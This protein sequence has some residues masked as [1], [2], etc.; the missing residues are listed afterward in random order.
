MS[1]FGERFRSAGYSVPKPLI[2]ID[3]KT[4][5]EHVID[6]FP[7]E[8]NFIFVCNRDHLQ[9]PDYRMQ[10][11]LQ[12]AC[13]TGKIVAIAPHRKG[14][15]H[16][17]MQAIDYLDLEK[18][19]VINYCDFTCFWDWPDFKHFVN[20]TKCAGAI[21]AYRGFHPHSLGSTYYAYLEESAG[22]WA[23]NI[24]EKKPFTS[25]PKNEFA[26]TGTYYFENGKLMLW[27][28]NEMIDRELSVNDEF[29]VSMAYKPLFDAGKKIAIY[30][31]QHFMQWGTPQ[32]LI[33]Y[34]QWSDLFRRLVE[35]PLARSDA[36]HEGYL[37]IPMAGLGSRFAKEG[38]QD[39]KPLIKV[40]GYP[41]VLRSALDMPKAKQTIFVTRQDLPG[42][43][44]IALNISQDIESGRVV[45]LAGITEGQAETCLLG[46]AGCDLDAPI[47]FAP[48]DSGAI[49]SS[50]LFADK[51]NSADVIVWGYRGHPAAIQNPTSFSWVEATENGDVIKVSLKHPL[52]NPQNDP[53]VIGAFTFKKAKYFK[54]AVEKLI[55]RNERVNK[56]FYTDAVINVAKENGLI[57]QLFEVDYYIGWGTPSEY[58]TFKYWQ[59]CFHKWAS[60]PYSLQKD[61]RIRRG[62]ISYLEK[63]YKKVTPRRPKN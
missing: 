19:V 12:R 21:P 52:Q 43:E 27:A 24:Q 28:F 20:E 42:N 17:V 47:T 23:K 61:S 38:Y 15:V 57:V 25:N 40:D 13:P 48:C 3:G 7:G 62:S 56:E 26:S 63:E 39:P 58:E 44:Q 22:L 1:G 35:Q 14:P 34:K 18:Q 2:P 45:T 55:L 10:E 60:H 33:E 49:F 54:E 8:H 5:I 50:A 6:L 11:I 51:L 16:A 4:I 53:I 41:M 32:D 46:M 29:Y 37:M 9:N 36:S 59:S 30:E 31:I